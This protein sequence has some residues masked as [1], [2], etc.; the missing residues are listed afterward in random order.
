MTAARPPF[1]FAASEVAEKEGRYPNDDERLGAV[2]RLGRAAGLSRVA[3]NLVRLP[4]GRRSSW[5]HAE[6][7]EEEFVYVVAGEVDAWIDGVLHPMRAGD[8]AGFAAGTGV[9]HSFVNNGA[10]EALLLVGGDADRADNRIYYPLHPQRRADLAP[11]EWWEDAPAA[12]LGPDE[13]TPARR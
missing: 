8:F 9:C 4:P 3:V 2:R 7:K 13:A 12:A 5:P 10:E 1:L 11:G 6:E